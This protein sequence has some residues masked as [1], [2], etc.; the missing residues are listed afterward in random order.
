MT[1]TT[2]QASNHRGALLR[3]WRELRHLTQLDLALDA[4]VSAR[5]INFLETGRTQP[6]R[7]ML[8]M[9]ANALD[10]PLRERNLLFLAAGYAP[11]YTELALDDA[12]MAEVRTALELILRQHEPYSTLACD[13]Y[14]NL[15]MA[16]ATYIT[17]LQYTLGAQ[18][19][20]AGPL[21]G[22][23]D[24]ASERVAPGVRPARAAAFYR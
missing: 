12:R 20:C 7:S 6:G 5:P 8:F 24:A 23:A 19:C 22:A 2:A 11:P 13:R 18:R 9:L 4:G 16:N 10:M 3:R 17:F 21:D 14:W 15:I 1:F